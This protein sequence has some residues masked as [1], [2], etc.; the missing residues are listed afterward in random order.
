LR[1]VLA[2]ERAHGVV[3]PDRAHVEELERANLASLH[4]LAQSERVPIE[5]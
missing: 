4:D 1:A 2:D 5:A 3:R